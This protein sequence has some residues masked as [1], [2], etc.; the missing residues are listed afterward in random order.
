MKPFGY[1]L[2]VDLY[3]C[4]AD[5][6]DIT[7]V[8]DFLDKA[9]DVIGVT[10]QAPPY[11]FHSPTEIIRDGK[12]IDCSDKAGIS[13][14]VPLVESAIS[15]H[16]LVPKAYTTINFFTCSDMTEQMIEALIA[17]SLETFKPQKHHSTVLLRGE[18]YFKDEC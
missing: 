7:L 3:F 13:A 12:I 10:K 4:Q 2:I 16:S 9:V 14:W 6:D 15:L 11:V 1:E 18:D 17:F 8:Y 5:I